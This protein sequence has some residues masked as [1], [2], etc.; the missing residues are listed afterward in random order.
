[1][2]KEYK[3]TTY[4]SFG[5]IIGSIIGLFLDMYQIDI[6]GAVGLGIVYTPIIGMCLG[7]IISSFLTK[8]SNTE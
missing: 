6:Y 2:M 8:K 4:I 1:M 7:V 5:L 3:R